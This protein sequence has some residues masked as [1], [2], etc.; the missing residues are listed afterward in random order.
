MTWL[1]VVALAAIAFAVAAFVLK[2]P[3]GAWTTLGAALVFGL[4]GY[5]MQ[6][7]PGL[8]AS[9]T[10]SGDGSDP[11]LFDVVET[12]RELIDLP[13]QSSAPLLV[14]ADA[15]ARRGRYVDA[16]HLLAGILQ[17]DP[18][19]FEAWLAQGNA[20]LEHAGGVLTP[21]ALYAYRRAAALKPEHLAPGYFIGLALIR[22]GRPAEAAEV[23]RA[24]LASG[25]ADAKGRA[26]LELQ[27]ERLAALLDATGAPGGRAGTPIA[28]QAP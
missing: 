7:R 27:V 28:D 22:S 19:D 1:P 18:R 9:P 3:R 24:T 17:N 12:R 13:E 26:L 23:W 16:S 14:T 21:S 8:P 2:L 25:P 15:M 11:V 6:A 5:A 4:A 10:A 20:L